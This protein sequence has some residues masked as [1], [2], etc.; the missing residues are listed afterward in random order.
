MEKTRWQRFDE[1]CGR[2]NLWIS[3]IGFKDWQ[4]QQRAEEALRA[5]READTEKFYYY[6]YLDAKRAA[7]NRPKPYKHRSFDKIYGKLPGTRY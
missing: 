1:W 4:R 2:V 6:A 7:R 3:M 5:Q